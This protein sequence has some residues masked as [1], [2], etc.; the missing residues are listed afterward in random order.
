MENIDFIT[1]WKAQNTKIEQTLAI[2]KKLFRNVVDGKAQSTLRSLKILKSGLLFFGILYL[3]ALS[4]L[5]I[6]ALSRYS[7]SWNYFIVSVT[8]I[9]AINLY[10]VI[11]YIK[12]LVWLHKIN[13]DGVV[14]DIQQKLSKLQLSIVNHTRIMY[15]Q[16]PF[17][18]T[19]YLS[20]NWFPQ[21]S[22]LA[23]TIFQLAFTVAAIYSSWWVYRNMTPENL[24]NK[25]IKS[26]LNGSGRETVQKA[27]DFYKEIEEYKVEE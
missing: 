11:T 27:M 1:I 13:Y 5:L 14:A 6:F 8:A 10:A 4:G 9:F 22:P 3:I 25:L 24:N 20:S 26:L 23:Y 19:F 15:L 2:N 7:P 17:F 16:T 12:H 18:T 21:S